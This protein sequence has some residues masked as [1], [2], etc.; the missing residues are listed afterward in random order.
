MAITQEPRSNYVFL[1]SEQIFL[2]N[3]F[4]TKGQKYLTLPADIQFAK[5]L[6]SFLN[7]RFTFLSK[8]Q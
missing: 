7:K 5:A 1:R 6:P 4:P 8:N 3:Q 2:K